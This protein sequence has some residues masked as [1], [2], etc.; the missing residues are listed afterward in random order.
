VR[1]KKRAKRAYN[2]QQ[3]MRKEE[4]RGGGSG[5]GERYKKGGR[6]EGLPG[7]GKGR[8]VG[9]APRGVVAAG[10][11]SELGGWRARGE[12]SKRDS[13]GRS[14]KTVPGQ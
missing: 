14:E 6:A 4:E 12:G 8:P 1:N 7:F 5:R 10:G 3:R 9:T 2:Q 13:A 11:I